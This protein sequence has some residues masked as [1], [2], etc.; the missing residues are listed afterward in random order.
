MKRITL[1]LVLTVFTLATHAKE[2]NIKMKDPEKKKKSS[3]WVCSGVEGSMLQL[4]LWQEP[5]FKNGVGNP[6]D[7][8]SILR[9][10]YFFNSG[11]DVNFQIVKGFSVFTGINMKNIG[12][13]VKLDTVK[14]KHRVY[15]MGLPIGLRWY[16]ANH[17]TWF[18][19]GIDLSWA[20][21]YKMKTFENGKG[22]VKFSSWFSDRVTTFQPSVF[23][24]VNVSGLS[25]AGNFYLNN[26]FNENNSIV[27]GY[28]AQI[29]TLGIGLNMSKK[30]QIPKIGK[31]PLDTV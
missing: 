22:K 14:Y 23:A 6:I 27:K 18:K 21:N 26:F 24:G 9:Y 15:T 19:A 1:L 28:K 10:S 25:I 11:A 7:L 5:T 20:F 2:S 17:K 12:M 30:K 29:V 13:I 4:G 31:K 3:R 16:K 8:K